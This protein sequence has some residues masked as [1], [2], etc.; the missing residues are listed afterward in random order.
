MVLLLIIWLD[1]SKIQV[2][3]LKI[4]IAF[5]I[6]SITLQ[7]EKHVQIILSMTKSVWNVKKKIQ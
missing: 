4:A 2:E 1:L 6:K 7:T 5:A 3:L